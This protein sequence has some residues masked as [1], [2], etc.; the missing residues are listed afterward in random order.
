MNVY[1]YL[2]NVIAEKGAAYLIL[3][4]PDKTSGEKLERF[5][6][7]CEKSGVDGFLVGGSLL[8]SN[9]LDDTVKTIN[10]IFE[11]PTPMTRLN[12]W[13]YKLDK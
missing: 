8:I 10:D 5:V 4:D 9:N 3:I 7:H 13:R 1:E 2:N 11:S 12:H 6:Q